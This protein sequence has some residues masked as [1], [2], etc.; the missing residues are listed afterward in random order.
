MLGLA[1]SGCQIILATIF[2]TTTIVL[3][4]AMTSGP[5]A[6]VIDISPNFASITVGIMSTFTSLTGFISPWLVGNLTEGRQH[7]VEAWKYVFGICA[8]L[9][10]I[11]GVIYLIFSDSSLQKWNYP[12]QLGTER[13]E[14]ERLKGD[15]GRN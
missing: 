6:S 9:Q 7:S 8:A 2:C 4:G 3:N 14:H 5:L 13:K 12:E 1:F 15:P 11:C 10:I